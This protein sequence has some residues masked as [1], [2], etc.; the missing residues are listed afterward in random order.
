VLQVLADLANE[1]DGG[2]GVLGALG[3]SL[4]ATKANE[5]R[6]CAHDGSLL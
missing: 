6:G 1:S 5:G 2:P 4:E 3:A